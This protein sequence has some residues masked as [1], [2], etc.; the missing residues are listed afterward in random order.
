MS[1]V[2]FSDLLRISRREQKAA[3]RRYLD[4]LKIRYRLGDDGAPWTT[5]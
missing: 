5:T 3:V 4:K 1:I 2:D